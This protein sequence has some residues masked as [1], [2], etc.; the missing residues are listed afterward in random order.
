M[1][2][3][4]L[5]FTYL[6][7]DDEAALKI[8]NAKGIPYTVVDYSDDLSNWEN[9][10]IN[11]NKTDIWINDR[12]VSTA[13]NAEKIKSSGSFLA[14]ID[15]V[16]D[17]E[18]LCDVY[19]AG[20]I[21]FT[22]NEYKAKRVY[23]GTDYIIL[24]PEIK[25]YRKIRK[26]VNRVIVSLGGA[27]PFDTSVSVAEELIKTDFEF[28]ILLGGDASCENKLSRIN[29]GR[30]KVFRNVPSAIQLFSGYDLAIT[31]GGVTCCEANS[32]GLPCIII[33][34]A[35]HE[36]NT[37]KYLEKIG[38]SVFAGGYD[39]WNHNLIDNINDLNI[40]QMSKAGISSFT[41]DGA[42]NIIENILS[43]FNNA[44]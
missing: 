14:L 29:R 1:K 18:E 40:E 2:S 16:G 27:D 39:N 24:N 32:A 7:N 12:F 9:K 33:A 30:F 37:G 44:G 36:Y 41:L 20:M 4:N 43:E 10:I 8:L 17:A 31:G 13:K 38:S 21:S 11:D 15:D 23:K 25:K 42:Q 28:D 6:I 26:A 5:D 19:F 22:K 34:N 35:P 3:K